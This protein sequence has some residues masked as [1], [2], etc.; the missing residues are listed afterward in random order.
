VF[1]AIFVFF[2]GDSSF[3]QTPL[4]ALTGAENA[5]SLLRSGQVEKTQFKNPQPALV[6]NHAAVKSLAADIAA[7]LKPS[8]ISESL[9]LY[10]K[11]EAAAHR[12]TQAE[13]AALYNECLALSSLA[14][15]KY[16]S[17]S[18]GE[19]RLFYETSAAVSGPDGKTA[20]PDPVFNAPPEKATVY[21]KQKDLSFGSNVYRY[22]Y[23]A[24]ADS[25]VFVQENLTTMNYKI[26]PAVRK[27]NLRSV[28]AV[29]DLGDALLVYAAS[30]AKAASVPGMNDRI[31]DSFSTRVEAVYRWFA[32]RA[33][34]ALSS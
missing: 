21:A 34:K 14:G 6:P 32:S 18:R 19:M 29:I 16:Y 30:F 9:F 26:V 8:V 17:A 27:H 25:L 20:I 3:A 10:K 22:D 12:W 4:E 13:R 15:L 1:F 2:V 33:D 5:A 23:Y 11:P 7:E 24:S 28:V 31:G